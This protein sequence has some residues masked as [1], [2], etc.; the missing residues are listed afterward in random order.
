MCFRLWFNGSP[1]IFAGP[2]VFYLSAACLQ[3]RLSP[4]SPVDSGLCSTVVSVKIIDN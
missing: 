4:G 3:A 2:C 1:V